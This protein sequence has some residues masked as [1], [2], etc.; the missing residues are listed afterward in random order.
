MDEATTY[1]TNQGRASVRDFDAA[2]IQTREGVSRAEHRKSQARVI[3]EAAEQDR[4]AAESAAETHRD[5]QE[6]VRQTAGEAGGQMKSLAKA[7]ADDQ[8]VGFG[9]AANFMLSWQKEVAGFVSTRIE[10]NMRFGRNL[11]EARD[12]STLLQLYGQFGREMMTDYA[13]CLTSIAD[14][15][16]NQGRQRGDQV[17]GGAEAANDH[18]RA[19]A[20]RIADRA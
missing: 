18:P 14:R 3:E 16:I 4:P 2:A 6:R 15:S 1:G 8:S 10:R 13:T 11:L 17:I 20:Q 5:A 19:G 12:T 9:G 7:W